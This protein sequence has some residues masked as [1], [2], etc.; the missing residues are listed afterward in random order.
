MPGEIISIQAGQCGNQ[1]GV[2]F[3]EQLFIEH[4]IQPDGTRVIL[5]ADDPNKKLDRTDV[6]FYQSEDGR[7][8]PRSVLI[9]LEPRVIN[10]ITTGKYG[11][12]FNP[13]NI[14]MAPEGGGAGN[15]WAMGFDHAEKKA[16]VFLDMLD[17]EADGSESLEGFMLTHSVAGGTGSG[18]GSY[19]LECVND[20]FPKKLIQTVSIFPQSSDVVVQPYNT[21]L[22]LKR[23]AKN[24]DAVLVFENKAL[25]QLALTNLSIQNPTF[26][27]SNQLVSTVLSS[28][29]NTLRYPGYMYNSLTS[30]LSTM[31][32]N[33]ELHFLTTSYTP[34]TGDFVQQ[35]K[36]VRKSNAYD[37]VLELLDKKNRMASIDTQVS[38]GAYI[39]I[40]DIL[41]GDIDQIDLRK[42]ILKAQQ[43]T[44]FVPWGPT[45]IHVA[46]GVKSPYLTK[47]KHNNTVG[48]M[49]SNHT[50]IASVLKT[51]CSQYD[52]FISRNAF[53]DSY[54]KF[55][56]FADDLDEFIDSREVTQSVIDQY[57]KAED[58]NYLDGGDEDDDI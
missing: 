13:R 54:R 16:D 12:V 45:G 40:F 20:R 8:T 28:Y 31:I 24:A 1:I 39:S 43:R 46:Q 34:F 44:R 6:F 52:R 22:T 36:E 42:G 18:V 53:L 23:L 7:Y 38:D 50:N 3:W 17:R 35:A 48:L 27:Q 37:V 57:V 15:N 56:M 29:T 2:Q 5:P 10:T 49:L 26:T 11:G 19:L 47:K 58:I 30:I 32:P 41:C 25:H 21:I 14:Y 9:D 4:G 55:P 51:A 33:P